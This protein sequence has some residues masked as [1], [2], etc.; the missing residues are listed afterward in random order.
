ML[1]ALENSVAWRGL[2]EPFKQ[3]KHKYH[4]S[5]E[6]HDTLCHRAGLARWSRLDQTQRKCLNDTPF[7]EFGL[8]KSWRNHANIIFV[9]QYKDW[10]YS[11]LHDTFQNAWP[12]LAGAFWEFWVKNTVS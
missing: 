11:F 10:E 8:L 6:L 5:L 1:F 4:Q 12:V 3:L 7:I 9:I 2:S